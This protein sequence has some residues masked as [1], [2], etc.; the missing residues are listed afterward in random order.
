VSPL[1]LRATAVPRWSDPPRIQAGK[2]YFLLGQNADGLWVVRESTRRR[3][4]LFLSREAAMRFARLESG[5]E[6]P[7]V[8]HVPDVLEF[9]YAA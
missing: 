5:A 9:D 8:L 6:R 7:A 3:G 2:S 4:G 1:A